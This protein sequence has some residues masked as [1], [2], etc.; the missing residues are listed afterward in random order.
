VVNEEEEDKDKKEH[1]VD[2]VVKAGSGLAR[3]INVRV[4]ASMLP[5]S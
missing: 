1:V 4:R 3:H 5:L 2:S